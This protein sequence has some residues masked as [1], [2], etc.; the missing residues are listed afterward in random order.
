MGYRRQ[1]GLP[2]AGGFMVYPT[3]SRIVRVLAPPVPLATPVASGLAAP[4]WAGSYMCPW[5]ATHSV[6]VQG[7]GTLSGGRLQPPRRATRPR[8]VLVCAHVP[9][10]RH[11]YAPCTLT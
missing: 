8:T 6:L 10:V 5:Q 4:V 9:G 7:V 3:G 1:Y 11:G 2:V